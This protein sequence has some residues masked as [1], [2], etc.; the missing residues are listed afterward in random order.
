MNILWITAEDTSPALGCYG[1]AYATTPHID[2]LATEGVLYT[3][4]FATAPVC[5]P[6][7]SCLINGL[8]ATS[9]GTQ[10]MRSAFPIPEYMKGFPSI[11]RETGSYTSNNVKTDYN[12]G[13]WETIISASW[14]ENSDNAHWRKRKGDRPFFSV[15]NQ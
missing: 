1:D 10:Q 14:D 7:R 9:Q 4:A 5:S 13:N 11:L 8:P 12:N 15:F 2:Q 3:H 6:S